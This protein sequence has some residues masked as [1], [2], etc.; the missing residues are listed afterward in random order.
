MK[1]NNIEKLHTKNEL[2]HQV[3]TICNVMKK[4]AGK[5]NNTLI[6]HLAKNKTKSTNRNDIANILTDNVSQNSACE[7]SNGKISKVK[8]KKTE[9]K[10]NSISIPKNRKL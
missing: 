4:R 1:K 8:K 2:K 10:K 7:K 9:E 5:N 3:N 6:K